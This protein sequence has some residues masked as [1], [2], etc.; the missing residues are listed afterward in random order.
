MAFQQ[1]WQ[2]ELCVDPTVCADVHSSQHAHQFG[3]GV[4]S[5]ESIQKTPK[6]LTEKLGKQ[7]HSIH[8]TK[9]EKTQ[10]LMN[11]E[12]HKPVSESARVL[13]EK[14][15]K[16]KAFAGMELSSDDLI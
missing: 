2:W 7:G 16:C 5:T 13:D 9:T 4:A 11:T 15:S 12:N 14:T 6:N 10:R 1:R 8:F 3:Q